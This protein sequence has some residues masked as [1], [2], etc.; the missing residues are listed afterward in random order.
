[1]VETALVSLDRAVSG[2]APSRPGRPGKPGHGNGGN[3]GKGYFIMIEASRIDHAGHANDAAAH[4]HDTLMYNEVMEFVGKWIDEHE[5]TMMMSAA[6]H[7][8]GGLTTNG[9]DPSTLSAASHSFEY[10]QDLW[11]ENTGDER[12]FLVD[13]ILPGAGLS[14]VVSDAEVDELLASG[15]D[16]WE[17][18]TE[19]Q[20]ETAGVNWSTGGHTAGDIN[21]HGYGAGPKMREFK[22]DMAGN[23][24]N[25]E[26]PRYIE[27]VLGLDMDA[28][29]AKLRAVPAGWVAD[30]DAAKKVK[31]GN[32]KSRDGHAAGHAH[33]H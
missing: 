1:M 14:D 9:F 10:L 29:T 2:N 12:A 17:T 7:E 13:T 21:L 28:T 11:D 24:D 4:V 27:K 8:C 23:H 25:T 30:E 3:N 33:S 31:R 32:V 16:M 15:D 20:A 22:A 26:L 19:L 5:D 18:L 6:D